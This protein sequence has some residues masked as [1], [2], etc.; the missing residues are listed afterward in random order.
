V[1]LPSIK[2]EEEIFSMNKKL[3]ALAVRRGDCPGLALAQVGGSP[4]VTL[5]GA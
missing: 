5:Y 3:I 4:G 2:Y 1:R